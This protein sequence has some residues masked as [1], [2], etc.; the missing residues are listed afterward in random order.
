MLIGF[1]VEEGG[2][3]NYGEFVSLAPF[4]LVIP[5]HTHYYSFLSKGQQGSQDYIF[6][7][8]VCVI[9]TTTAIYY[10]TLPTNLKP[11]QPGLIYIYK[12]I[13]ANQN[14]TSTTY[15]YSLQSYKNFRGKLLLLLLLL[16]LLV[17]K[18]TICRL[19]LHLL[20]TI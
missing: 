1:E 18:K 16:F 5:N 13:N 8:S 11:P 4:L 19:D 6:F 14:S 2:D 9:A 15:T 17:K 12:D 20:N 10:S 3:H 7:F